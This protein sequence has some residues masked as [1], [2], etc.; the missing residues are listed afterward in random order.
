MISE[1]LNLVKSSLVLTSYLE[2]RIFEYPQLIACDKLGMELLPC[3]GKA[4]SLSLER[5]KNIDQM[6]AA[7]QLLLPQIRS[8]IM[9][10]P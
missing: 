5:Y 9:N 2:R 10:R 1:E 4:L 8:Q 6:V 3:Q 7:M